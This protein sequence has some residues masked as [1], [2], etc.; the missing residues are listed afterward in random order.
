MFLKI[1]EASGKTNKKAKKTFFSQLLIRINTDFGVA[2][3][4]NKQEQQQQQQHE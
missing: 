2:T 3:D 4:N 1:A